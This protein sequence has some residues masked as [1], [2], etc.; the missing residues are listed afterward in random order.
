MRWNQA[1][2]KYFTDNLFYDYHSVNLVRKCEKKKTIETIGK[3][4]M[5]L[6]VIKTIIL[7]SI[8]TLYDIL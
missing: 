8:P 2:K 5:I 1:Y 6:Y 3:I 4:F 7:K